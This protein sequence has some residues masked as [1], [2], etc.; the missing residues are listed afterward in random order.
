M[1]DFAEVALLAPRFVP[2]PGL[3][4]YLTLA[5]CY[6]SFHSSLRAT[7]SDPNKPASA[8][9]ADGHWVTRINIAPQDG[10]GMAHGEAGNFKHSPVQTNTCVGLLNIFVLCFR[11]I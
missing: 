8:A 3:R 7:F 11:N 2:P 4:S 1:E 6:Y 10:V 5:T 9:E